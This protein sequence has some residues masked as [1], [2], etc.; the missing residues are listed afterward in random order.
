LAAKLD[1]IGLRPSV[2]IIGEPT[3]MQVIDAHKGCY[4]YTTHFTGAEGHGSAHDL[5]VNAVEYATR[6]VAR[7]LQLKDALTGG[8][9]HNVIPGKARVDWEMRLVHP[10]DAAFVKQ[11]LHVYCHDILIPACRPSARTR[12]SQPR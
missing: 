5:G 6:F 10:D 2:A 4:E 7:L 3:G 11:D 8:V 1:Q 9:A 12:T